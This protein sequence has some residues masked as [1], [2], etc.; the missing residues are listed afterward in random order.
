LEKLVGAQALGWRTA[1]VR[2][3][4]EDSSLAVAPAVV[5]VPDIEIDTVLDLE[6]AL[7]LQPVPVTP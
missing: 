6:A 4:P 5:A 7:G 2:L 3:K 1:L